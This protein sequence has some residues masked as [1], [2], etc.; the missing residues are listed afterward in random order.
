MKLI[1][2]F[3]LA[4]FVFGL[5]ASAHAFDEGIEYESISPRVL[6]QTSSGKVEVVELFWY[7]CPHCFHFEPKLKRWLKKKPAHVEFIRVPA[8]FNPRWKLH[9]K[10]YYTAEVLGLTEKLH[11]KIFDAYHVDR[12]RLASESAIRALFVKL[13]VDGEVFDNTFN[14][15]S[16]DA[17]LR[18]AEDLTRRYGIR[19]VPAMVVNGKYRTTNKIS[20]HATS[21]DV[22]DHLVKKERK[23]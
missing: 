20:G 23:K 6:P 3:C 18:Q 14:S 8:T 2:L 17:K 10:M 16:V 15:F 5:N 1:R 4:L 22:V 13:G 11:Q 7:G 21:L 19:G 9:A 12:N